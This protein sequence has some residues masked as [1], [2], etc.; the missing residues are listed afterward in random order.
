M[1]RTSPTRRTPAWNAACCG[2]TKRTLRASRAACAA[3]SVRTVSTK[4]GGGGPGGGAGV[5]LAAFRRFFLRLAAGT[6]PAAFRAGGP[7]LARASGRAAG[8]AFAAEGLLRDDEG[9]RSSAASR[10]L[11]PASALDARRA[12]EAR[13][14]TR[15]SRASIAP[16]RRRRS[17]R[18]GRRAAS[19]GESIVDC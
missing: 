12:L 14:R 4:D 13:S 17:A 18:G 1:T 15:R 7:S 9:A 10:A 3:R 2:T 11:P 16:S 5:S 19:C 6:A 8:P